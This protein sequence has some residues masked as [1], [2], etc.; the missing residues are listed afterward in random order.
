M[1]MTNPLQFIQQVRAEIAK[2]VWPT[3]REVLLTTVMVFIMA[4]LT[5]IF[6]AIVDLLIRG[7]L[8]AVLNMFG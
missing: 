7:G 1:A 4:T 5:A 2:V 6:F 8:Q 3:R